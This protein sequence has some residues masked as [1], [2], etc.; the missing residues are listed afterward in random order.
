MF[1]FSFST[2][3]FFKIFFIWREQ[4]QPERKSSPG[5][6]SK[7]V[8]VQAEAWVAGAQE[9]GPFSAAFSGSFAREQDQKWSSKDKNWDASVTGGSSTG[10]IMML[11][12]SPTQTWW[13]IFMHHVPWDIMIDVLPFYPIGWTQQ[14]WLATLL[15][16][17]SDG[18]SWHRKWPQRS[19]QPRKGTAPS[20][21]GDPSMIGP[22]YFLEFT[23]SSLACQMLLH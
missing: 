14:G 6:C 2:R 15:S 8:L 20:S 9:L 18:S 16:G 3:Y 22:D 23:R 5:E 13:N 21:S 7:P 4:L 17:S 1:S 11:Q 19:P 10:Y 12:L